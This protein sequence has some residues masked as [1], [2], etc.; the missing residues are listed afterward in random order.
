MPVTISPDWGV[1]TEKHP[2]NHVTTYEHNAACPLKAEI[3]ATGVRTEYE[4]DG[5]T[6]PPVE[7]APRSQSSRLSILAVRPAAHHE[8]PERS[9]SSHGRYAAPRTRRAR[10]AGRAAVIDL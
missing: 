5:V 8:R 6:D 2:G 7:P 4:Y 3:D 10:G 1:G 9:A